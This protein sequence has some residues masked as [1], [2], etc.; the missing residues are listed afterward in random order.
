MEKYNNTM[1][2]GISFLELIGNTKILVPKIQRD[3]A[4][5]RL[6]NKASEIRDSFLS[7][8]F[9]SLSSSDNEPLLLD[10]IY[11][12]THDTVFTP[13]DGQQRLT[14]LFLLHWYFIPQEKK[15][16]L[17]TIDGNSCYSQFSYETR[18]SSKDFCNALVTHSSSDLKAIRNTENERSNSKPKQLSDIIKNQSWFQWSWHKDPT[19]KAMLIM[20]DELDKRASGFE[21]PKLVEIWEQLANGKILFH[22]LPLEQF[23]LT[24]ELYVKMNAR[25]KELSQFDIF[26]S[27]LEE[28]M[29]KNDVNQETQDIWRN[30]VD[31]I[32]IDIFWNRLAK[33]YLSDHGK[34]ENEVVYVNSVENGY[35]RF[36]KRMMVFHLY[37]IDN[38][39]NV[40]E[41]SDKDGLLK[42]V[43][44]NRILP[45]EFHEGENLIDKIREYSVRNDIL[46]LMPFL[47]KT[48]FFNDSLFD[49]IIKTFA[50]V[51]YRINDEKHELSEIINGVWF[52]HKIQ[53]LFDVFIDE[54]IDYDARIQ[55]YALLKFSEYH[56]AEHI[57]NNEAMKIE[58]NSWMR[59]IRNL[60]TNTNTYYYNT[61][62]DFY[63]SIKVI[64]EWSE[65]VYRKNPNN[66]ILS[67]LCHLQSLS[68]FNNDQINEEIIK[69]RFIS[70]PVLGDKWS[71]V[72]REAE[73]H[74]YFLGQIRFLL[75]WSEGDVKVFEKYMV[76]ISSFFDDNGI[77]R[78]L[79]NKHLFNNTLMCIDQWYL[80]NNCFV[81]DTD[82]N[83]DWSWKRYLREQDKAK[84]IKLLID[85][86][87]GH[88]NIEDSCQSYIK[89]NIPTD[90]RKCFIEFPQIYDELYD[91]K[92]SWWNWDDEKGD[93]DIALLSKTRWS[94]RHKEL[95]TFYWHLKFKQNENDTY[96]DSTNDAT[97]FTAIFNREDRKIHLQ[98]IATSENEWLG[99]YQIMSWRTS[100]ENNCKVHKM[101]SSNHQEIEDILE[102]LLI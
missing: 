9:D 18:I 45:F 26:K 83:R 72:I 4:Q 44:L 88:H 32:W 81:Y 13:L 97:P 65:L 47:C 101:P 25:G 31:S 8:I 23:A 38:P 75:D 91:K 54:K 49:F 29:R 63:K 41:F 7:S 70:D 82:K 2:Q 64:D 20:L 16:L 66:T 89:N 14:T 51:I 21:N 79:S 86:L 73:E 58:L 17:F 46:Q 68:G 62:D 39:I 92:I 57:V 84:N 30:N 37:S 80:L 12:S 99:E 53:N 40:N 28:Q 11:G 27:T 90:W 3:Y 69:A 100:D 93:G 94:S 34:S 76:V 59:I 33:P 95:R 35:L 42:I 24:D 96:L 98:F 36:F 55:Y 56:K 22:L 74:K 77:I 85:V 1:Q 60:S 52:E 61:W 15:S 19:V 78:E 5:G 87:D 6:D 50:N 48:K 71:K 43:E 10:F 67:F 102:S